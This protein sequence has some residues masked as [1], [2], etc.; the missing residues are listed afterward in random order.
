MTQ[1]RRNLP[2]QARQ[3]LAIPTSGSSESTALALRCEWS[4]RGCVR[5]RTPDEATPP[6]HLP[7][8]RATAPWLG[9]APPEVP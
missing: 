8:I 1:P 6:S 7:L 4:P 9:G 5:T 3:K 2:G